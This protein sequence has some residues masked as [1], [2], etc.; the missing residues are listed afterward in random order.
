MVL[1]CCRVWLLATVPGTS[2]ALAEREFQVLGCT[3]GSRTHTGEVLNCQV[4]E[5]WK[6]ISRLC[7]MRGDKQDINRIFAEARTQAL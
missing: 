1:M 4:K 5:L 6:E 7:S 3:P 2:E